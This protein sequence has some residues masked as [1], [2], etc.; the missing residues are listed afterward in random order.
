MKRE[1]HKKE[2]KGEVFLSAPGDQK[3]PGTTG[4]SLSQVDIHMSSPPVAATSEGEVSDG[5]GG[6]MA[7]SFSISISV[8]PSPKREAISIPVALVKFNNIGDTELVKRGER[9][10]TSVGV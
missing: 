9:V 3:T 2:P 4:S 7:R 6:N 1:Q 5:C 10:S 8:S